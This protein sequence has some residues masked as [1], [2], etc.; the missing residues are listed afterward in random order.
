MVVAIVVAVVVGCVVDC[1]VVASDVC[2]VV[3]TKGAVLE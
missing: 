3:E 2:D 1:A